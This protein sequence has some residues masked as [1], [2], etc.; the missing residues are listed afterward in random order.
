MLMVYRLS[1]DGMMIMD[2]LVSLMMVDR[3]MALTLVYRLMPLMM[4]RWIDS[5]RVRENCAL[6]QQRWGSLL[7]TRSYSQLFRVCTIVSPSAVS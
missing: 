2:R 3:M 7:Q 6:M 5:L 4:V 1:Y